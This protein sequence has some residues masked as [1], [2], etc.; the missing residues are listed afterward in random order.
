MAIGW[1]CKRCK[2]ECP[3]SNPRCRGEAR[4]HR[5]YDAS[6]I[7]LLG[8]QTGQLG[9]LMSSRLS[10]RFIVKKIV[11]R[12]PLPPSFMFTTPSL[13]SLP[14]HIPEKVTGPLHSP[15]YCSP[16]SDLI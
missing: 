14:F 7:E 10:E 13:R 3:S 15:L 6:I 16:P 2:Q 1:K 4:W 12:C 8:L 11:T 9:L 5:G